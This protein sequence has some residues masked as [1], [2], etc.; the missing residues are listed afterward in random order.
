MSNKG[1]NICL[2]LESFSITYFIY[3]FIRLYDMWQKFIAISFST[4]EKCICG[5]R[6][7]R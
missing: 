5:A 3:K 7:S 6:K 2:L 1:T 4:T